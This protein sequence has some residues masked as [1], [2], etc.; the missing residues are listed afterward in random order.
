MY[1][2]TKRMLKAPKKYRL[3]KSCGKFN[4]P[5]WQCPNFVFLVM[6]LITLGV[7]LI[8]Y[9]IGVRRLYDSFIVSL[10]TL[11]IAVIL[12][13]LSFIITK[14]FERMAEASR[15]KSEMIDIVSHQLRSPLTNIK[16]GLDFLKDDAQNLTSQNQAG[17]Y[18]SLQENIKR[19]GGLIDNLLLVSRIESGTLPLN[20]E[21]VALDKLTE[22]SL[23]KFKAFLQASNIVVRTDFK[24]IPLQV[25]ADALWLSQIIDNLIDNAIKYSHGNKEINIVLYK[26]GNKIRFEIK[27]NG[28]GIAK[29][30]QRYI[31]EKFFRSESALKK[32]TNGSGLGLHIAKNIVEMLGGKIGFKSKQNKGTM[33]WF[34]LPICN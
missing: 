13:L 21:A 17:Y 2:D 9:F 12:L 6:G 14:S 30:E 11:V 1:K 19:M 8:S 24:D 4:V 10:F 23:N 5:L 31:F 25:K 27:D 29:E 7:I 32:Q 28:I 3:F 20:K 15:M 33:F 18:A 16:F 22:Q 34:E 26:K